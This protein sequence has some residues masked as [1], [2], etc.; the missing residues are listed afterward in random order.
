M[1]D[2]DL[3]KITQNPCYIELVAQRTR[4]GWVLTAA[5]LA[6]Y[7]GYILLIAFDKTLLAK[8]I[9]DGVMTWGMPIGLLVIIFTI[10]IT[11]IY[12]RHANSTYDELTRRIKEE[13]V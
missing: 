11:G 1:T 9:G 5:V 10:V 3:A 7:Y 6:V 12:V 2:D 13:A 8:R 4:L